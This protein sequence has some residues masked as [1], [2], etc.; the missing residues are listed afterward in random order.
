MNLGVPV[1]D[2][3]FATGQPSHRRFPLGLPID[4]EV[5]SEV[6]TVGYALPSGVRFVPHE[7]RASAQTTRLGPF[8]RTAEAALL[9]GETL[10]LMSGSAYTNFINWNQLQSLDDSL[11]ILAMSLLYQ[12]VNGWEECCGAIGI[13]LRY[14]LSYSGS[15]VKLIVISS[16]LSIHKRIWE[17][18]RTP[19]AMDL[20]NDTLKATMAIRSATRMVVDIS[21]KF[22][23]DL[24][25][26]NLYALPP[27][28]AYCV[29]LAAMLHIQFAGKVF[30]EPEW[31]SDMECMKSTLNHF[32]KRWYIGR[33]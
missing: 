22:H 7:S 28:A 14:A 2:I 6:S 21:R 8:C 11:Q 26:I 25:F 5:V 16:L 9:L 15:N 1:E 24:A 33:K 18:S 19:G 4:N 29:Y 32:G 20:H 27:P 23:M 3:H 13:C 31:T 17:M 10:E 30:M 12:A